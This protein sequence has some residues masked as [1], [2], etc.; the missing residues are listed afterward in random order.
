MKTLVIKLTG[1]IGLL[2]LLIFGVGLWDNIQKW[3]VSMT[4]E[5]IDIGAISNNLVVNRYVTIDGG[6]LDIENAFE[7][8]LTTKES[9][10]K[11]SSNFYIPVITSE[12]KAV[13]IVKR[14]RP[15]ALSDL[16]SQ[17]ST[18][19]LLLAQSALSQDMLNAFTEVYSFKSKLFVLDQ[20]F[21]PKSRLERAKTLLYPLF[22]ILCMLLLRFLLIRKSTDGLIENSDKV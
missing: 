7:E 4:P 22:I 8:S 15:P 21:Q 9:T 5:M 16:I 18:S 13:Y 11:I 12:D 1:Y 19:G 20:T 6:R 17:V 2:G 10:S 14:S 3:N